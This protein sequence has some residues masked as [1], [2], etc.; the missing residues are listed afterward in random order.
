MHRPYDAL[1]RAIDFFSQNLHLDQITQYGFQLFNDLVRPELAIMYMLDDTHYIPLQTY[2]YNTE[3]SSIKLSESHHDFAIRNGFILTQKQTMERYFD[4]S[5]INELNVESIMPLISGNRLLGFIFYSGADMVPKPDNAFMTRFNNMFNLALEKACKFEEH[6]LMKSEIDK[7]L[8]NLDSLSHTTKLLL[9]ELEVDK[10]YQLCIDVIRELTSSAVTSFSTRCEVTG[11]LVTRAYQDIITFEKRIAHVKLKD[12]SFIPDKVIYHLSDDRDILNQIFSNVEEF[13]R[14]NAQYVVLLLKDEVCGFITI[15]SPIG[16]LKYENKLLEQIENVAG[17]SQL[18]LTNAKQ[19]E[20]IRAQKKS[21]EKQSF[22]LKKINHSVKTIN[23]AESLDELCQV[24]MDTLQYGFGVESGFIATIVDGKVHLRSPLGFKTNSLEPLCQSQMKFHAEDGMLISYTKP[25]LTDYFC[26]SLVD[27]LP[28]PNCLIIAPIQTLGWQTEP[29]GC[30]V[31]CKLNVALREEQ[32]IL[33]DSLANSIAPVVKQFYQIDN[34]HQRY[35]P[36]P[37]IKIR[38]L[39][40][41][42]QYDK[43]TYDINYTVQLRKIAN[44]PFTP[45]DYS[46]FTNTDFVH[47]HDI[48]VLFTT[49]AD[50]VCEMDYTF[51]PNTFFEITQSIQNLHMDNM[52]AIPQVIRQS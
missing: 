43:D 40:S 27:L 28:E 11:F 34:L 13:E 25:H 49:S 6:T 15:G 23:S 31:V 44:T 50:P 19:F 41:S 4:K 32:T 52:T 51:N 29:L 48:I 30:I 7:R 46:E 37:E 14:L 8:F 1:L 38:E 22:L 24:T 35:Q 3:I 26:D 39:Y 33:I 36:N 2:G 18:A 12:Q 42:Y 9:S 45:V 20:L 16:T 10:I 47:L 17:L 21:M 5:L